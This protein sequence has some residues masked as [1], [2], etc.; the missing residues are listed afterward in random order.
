MFAPMC[1]EAL[2]LCGDEG[3]LRA[4]EQED[5]LAGACVKQHPEV[6]WREGQTSRMATTRYATH[7]EETGCNGAAFFEQVHFIDNI[8]GKETST[9]AVAEG[10]W[11]IVVGVTSEKSIETGKV[12][13]SAEL[14]KENNISS[15]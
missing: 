7:V 2:I 9:A 10:F 8:E 14:L 12:L 6:A 11:P 3:C 1:Y 15:C 5:F 4:S 13:N